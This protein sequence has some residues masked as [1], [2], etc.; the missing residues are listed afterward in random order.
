MARWSKNAY[1]FK[2]HP[3]TKTIENNR[4][5]LV[6]IGF[7]SITI[8]SCSRTIAPTL[9]NR[10]WPHNNSLLTQNN[11][12]L[13]LLQ[14][15]GKKC[16]KN[17]YYRNVFTYTD[18]VDSTDMFVGHFKVGPRHGHDHWDGVHLWRVLFNSRIAYITITSRLVN[19]LKI[20]HLFILLTNCIC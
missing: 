5:L 17:Y 8:C 4:L 19:I 14:H 18:I 6:I 9:N 3:F 7:Y 20:T 15:V 2:C 1:L 12:L 11:R 16:A 10:L 13:P